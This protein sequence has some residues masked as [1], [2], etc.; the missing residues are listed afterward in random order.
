MINC[1]ICNK[2]MKEEK[3]DGV[4]I[5][6]CSEH[7]VWLDKGELHDLTEANRSQISWWQSLLH[8]RQAS[9]VDH[10]RKLQCPHCLNP[11]KLENYQATQLDWCEKHGIW[12]DSGELEIILHNLKADEGYVRGMSLRLWEQKF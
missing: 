1:P 9:K 6:I 10:N 8:T 5:D 12:L 3:K 11:M 4:T 2:Q 7:G